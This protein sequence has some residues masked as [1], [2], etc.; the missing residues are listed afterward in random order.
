[1]MR[2]AY[3]G[4]NALILLGFHAVLIV[5]DLA[6]VIPYLRTLFYPMFNLI[7]LGIAVLGWFER[8]KF[9]TPSIAATLVWSASLIFWIAAL[10][11]RIRSAV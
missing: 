8:D 2:R 1:M 9:K 7:A 11:I 3:F 5:L 4:T 10:V 6:G